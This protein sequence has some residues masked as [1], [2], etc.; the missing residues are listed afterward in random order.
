MKLYTE[1]EWFDKFYPKKWGDWT[2]E[3][4][5]GMFKKNPQATSCYWMDYKLTGIVLGDPNN[6][7]I[8]K[9]QELSLDIEQNILEHFFIEC[10]DQK[11]EKAV[12]WFIQPY[13][14]PK[15][16]KYYANILIRKVDSNL[17][18]FNI[19]ITGSDDSC[20]GK[21]FIGIKDLNKG[22]KDIKNYGISIIQEK[23]QQY[24]RIN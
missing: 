8:L 14:Q 17:D 20:F 19:Y 9:V 10:G 2:K 7:N 16:K 4:N 18:L 3:Y 24:Y 22:I 23:D 15:T 11:D 21:D 5:I 1:K 13:Y 12:S 6:T